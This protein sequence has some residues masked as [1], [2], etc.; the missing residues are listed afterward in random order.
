MKVLKYLVAIVLLLI[1]GVFA[2]GLTLPNTMHLQRSATIDAPACTVMAQLDNYA[3]FNKWSPWAQYD[4]DARY[5][6]A[7][8]ARGVG[9][10]QSWS[11]NDKVGTGT[12]EIVEVV[13]CTL[14]RSKLAFGG[15]ADNR[16]VATFKLSPQGAGTSVDWILDG[17]FGGSIV[18]Q[19]MSRYFSMLAADMIGADYDRGLAN[20]KALAEKLPKADFAAL[21]VEEIDA[22][23]VTV[24]AV[25][26]RSSTESADIGKAYAEAYAKIMG[27]IKAH[28][29]NEAGPPIAV[30]RKWDEAGKVF[31][32]D[33]GIPVDRGDVPA[34][35]GEGEVKLAQTYAGKALKITH[36]GPYEG[37]AQTYAMLKAYLAAYGREKNGDEWEEYVSDPGKTPAA[38]LITVIYYPVK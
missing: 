18:D 21:K 13:P 4:P 7:G 23:P 5:T 10:R 17:E 24:A 12:Q 29:L 14:V 2:Y 32:F 36:V 1:A 11:G 6:V 15:F 25:A 34:A 22:A 30:T 37:L 19:V 26:G 38:E 31:E 20:L 9:A 27:F 8:P 16:Y 33:A 3:G 28:N 35:D